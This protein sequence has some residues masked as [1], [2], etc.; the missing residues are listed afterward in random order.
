MDNIYL[1]AVNPDTSFWDMSKSIKIIEQIL[2]DG[3]LLPRRELEANGNYPNSKKTPINFSGLDYI[4]L[5]DYSKKDCYNNNPLYK[6]YTAYSQ[7]VKYS[8]SLGFANTLPVI[9]PTILKPFFAD[10]RFLSREELNLI[11]ERLQRLG[12]SEDERYSDFPDEV[13]VKGP[14]P[15][16]KFLGLVIPVRIITQN[17]NNPK[18]TLK[19]LKAVIK[20]LQ[21]LL[22]SYAYLTT[23]YELDT[24]KKLETEEDVYDAMHQYTFF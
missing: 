17:S 3:A 22:K 15:L 21:D 18:D 5:C 16:D 20:E 11:Y 7:Y 2:K 24:F 12:L 23:I 19:R 1:H 9:Q 6:D 10:C 4:S 13:Q 14:L 8:I